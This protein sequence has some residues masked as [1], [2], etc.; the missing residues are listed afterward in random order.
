MT[1]LLRLA[2]IRWRADVPGESPRDILCGVDLTI[3]PGER[4]GLIGR[5]GA[6]KTTLAAIMAGLR[7]PASGSVDA[8]VGAVGLAF[9]EPE[10]GFFEETVLADVAFGPRN[11]G[12]TEREARDRAADA[13]RRVGLDPDVFGARAPETLS[14]GE[15]RRAALAGVLA[16]GPQLVIFDEPT[17]GLDADGVRR[18]REIFHSLADDGIAAVLVT[19]DLTLVLE[20]CER[21]VLL[22]DGR[23][24]WEGA[25]ARLFD[26]CPEAWRT[27]DALGRVKRALVAIRVADAETP[28]TVAS[29]AECIARRS[30]PSST[31]AA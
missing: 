6:G 19:H 20:D 28:C 17:V 1:D 3:R 24:T 22:D 21:V 10:R 9:Q 5:S 29:L 7:E 23:I 31:G 18:F 13:L 30:G 8:P 11:R 27:E 15:A 26:G 14:G 16:F 25:A 4:V 12:D 2:N